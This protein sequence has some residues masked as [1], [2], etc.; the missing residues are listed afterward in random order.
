MPTAC[1]LQKGANLKLR[2]ERIEVW[3]PQ[4]EGGAS[5]RI[6]D[7]PIHDI[8]R[9]ILREGAQISSESLCALLRAD[10]PISLLGWNDRFAG[11]FLPPTNHHGLWRLKQYGK[12]LDA[13][14][15]LHIA[16][17]LVLAK[18]ANQRRVI[19]RLAANRDADAPEEILHFLQSMRRLSE[20][21]ADLEELR[22]Y[23]GAAAARYFQS[24]AAFLPE[25]FPFERRSTRPPH[26]P[27]NACISFGA[28]LLYN[29]MVAA[30]HSHGLD[31]ALGLLHATENG[32]WSLAL[33]LMEPFRPVLVEALA[34]DLFTHQMV[35]TTCFEPHRGG[36]YLSEKGR[37]IFVLQ[38]ERRMERQFMSEHAGHRTTLREQLSATATQFKSA[39]DHPECFLPFE[40]N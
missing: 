10:I 25:E 33:D 6:R 13:G 19:Q 24:W 27:V 9:V 16:R 32:R 1:I 35:D 18:I 39:L 28:T 30:I 20:L 37:R 21:T 36:I 5:S 12:T 29:E 23:E 17:R 31:P 7:I 15:A 3:A 4:E 26:N 8:D 2:S 11:S 14:F 40:M 22:G 34:L 38:Y